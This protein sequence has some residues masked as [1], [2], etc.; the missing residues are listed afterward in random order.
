MNVR[1]LYALLL[2]TLLAELGGCKGLL[3][4]KDTD[5]APSATPV[6]A[7]SAVIAPLL[8]AP[9]PE[10]PAP[11]AVAVDEKSVPTPQ[12][13]EDEAFEKVTAANFKAQ[14]ATL[15]TAISK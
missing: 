15:K 7:P 11:A 8:P 2:V 1:P 3:K 9:I 6:A 4:K 10:P 5:P 12:D 13:F 14:F